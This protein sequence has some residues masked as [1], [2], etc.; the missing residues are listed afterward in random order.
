M[1]MIF[2][3]YVNQLSVDALEATYDE[4]LRRPILKHVPR[5]DGAKLNHVSTHY[6]A[7]DLTWHGHGH[8]FSGEH[9]VKHVESG[10]ELTEH[11]TYLVWGKTCADRRTYWTG[12]RVSVRL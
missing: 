2:F 6:R 7:C 12:D 3:L 5:L 8:G 11:V 10:K 9:S 4:P 1:G